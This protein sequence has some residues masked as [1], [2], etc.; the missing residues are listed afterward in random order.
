MLSASIYM[1]AFLT[2]ASLLLLALS[3]P[4]LQVVQAPQKDSKLAELVRYDGDWFEEHNRR[5]FHVVR[6]KTATSI[7]TY[8]E[9]HGICGRFQMSMKMWHDPDQDA[10]FAQIK[11]SFVIKLPHLSW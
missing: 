3:L 10:Y 7:E 4:C 9:S 2:F 5:C 1:N 11:E 6:E 8:F